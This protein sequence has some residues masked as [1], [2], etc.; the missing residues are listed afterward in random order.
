MFLIIKRYCHHHSKR[1][2]VPTNCKMVDEVN[3]I[4]A[5]TVKIKEKLHNLEA[6]TVK[7]SNNIFSLYLINVY[8]IP[9]I[10]FIKCI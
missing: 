5:D 2:F 7:M 6:L 8:I 3:E 9:V 4:K 10:I 1:V